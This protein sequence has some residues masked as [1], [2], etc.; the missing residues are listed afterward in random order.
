M[1]KK[2]PP[3]KYPEHEKL[4]AIADKSQEIGLFLDWLQ[5]KGIVLAHWIG[6]P[7]QVETENGWEDRRSDTE[8]V[9]ERNRTTIEQ[10]LAE[11][12][13]IDTKKLATEKQQMYDE[14][15]AAWI[16]RQEAEGMTR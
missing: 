9:L 10:W 13:E 4:S 6:A 7:Y 8:M 14:M 12:F 5:G 11:Y 1:A 3:A 15:R 2:P 16:S